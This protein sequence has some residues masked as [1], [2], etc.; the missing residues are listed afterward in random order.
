MTSTSGLSK[1]KFSLN[2]TQ[3]KY[4]ACF[5]MVLDH[6]YHDFPT[7][8]PYFFTVLGRLVA[9]IFFFLCAEGFHY[10]RNKY[11]YMGLLLAG[12]V[13]MSVVSPI[14]V[15]LF[16]IY[17]ASNGAPLGIANNIFGTLFLCT[18]YMLAL[19]FL[20][21]GI[22]GKN[23]LKILI[24]VAVAALPI[25]FSYIYLTVAFPNWLFNV[26]ILFPNLLW[27]EGGYIFVLLG[28]LFYLFRGNFPLQMISLAAI[29]AVF[30]Y[31][32]I[33]YQ[34]P[35]VITQSLMVFAIFPLL[36][37]NGERGTGQKY[38]FYI[39]YPAHVYILYILLYFINH[40][41]FYG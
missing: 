21:T 34:S 29:S 10:T 41:A 31:Q 7:Q 17:Y 20:R 37:Y 25:L 12:S 38:F 3:L 24:G 30:L 16:P 35:S 28:F 4:L 22:Q 27:V 36:L 5:L 1:R 40:G 32:G 13:F 8:V 9:P 39:F 23:A 26:F 15:E 2:G 14:I 6:I 19:D 11:K 18:V 33:T